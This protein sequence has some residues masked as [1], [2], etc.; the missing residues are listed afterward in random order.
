MSFVPDVYDILRNH[1]FS[2]M[3]LPK[4]TWSLGF[5][6]SEHEWPYVRSIEK[7]MTSGC[8]RRM[9]DTRRRPT[10][11]QTAVCAYHV[12][13]YRARKTWYTMVVRKVHHFFVSKTYQRRSAD[14][15]GW[16]ELDYWYKYSNLR[17]IPISIIHSVR[18]LTYI[19]A[20]T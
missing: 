4:K 17:Q 5:P 13:L 9:E 12:P 8:I 10:D 3:F 19:G 7:L 14:Y 2:G 6:V 16:R 1:L 11:S 18:A 20:L 15:R